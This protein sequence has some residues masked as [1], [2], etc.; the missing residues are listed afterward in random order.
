MPKWT[1]TQI[2]WG[3]LLLFIVFEGIYFGVIQSSKKVTFKSADLKPGKIAVEKYGRVFPQVVFKDHQNKI[4]NERLF[5]NNKWSLIY[6]GFTRC[7]HVCPT[8]MKV[9]ENTVLQFATIALILYFA[10]ILLR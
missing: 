2:F 6:F 3:A 7:P 1:K 5:I 4:V 10:L 8:S 9:L